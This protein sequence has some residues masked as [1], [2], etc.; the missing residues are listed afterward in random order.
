MLSDDTV[1][2]RL[3]AKLDHVELRFL[4]GI[5]FGIETADLSFRR[6]YELLV[7]V[8]ERAAS[9]SEIPAAIYPAAIA[10][11]WAAIDSMHRLKELLERTPQLKKN[12][13]EVALF[14]RAAEELNEL[15]N[16][17]H[18]AR[19]DFHRL[20]PRE[21]AIWGVV[22]WCVP[23]GEHITVLGLVPGTITEG[24]Y[25][26]LNPLGKV[27]QPPVDLIA[28]KAFGQT[29]QLSRLHRNLR[30]L[31][32]HLESEVVNRIVGM[33]GSRCDMLVCFDVAPTV[34]ADGS[35]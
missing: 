33:N 26:A 29:A 27:V 31:A 28:I 13:P 1:F 21:T 23:A 18:H 4:D 2:R 10:D 12:T 15:R 19:E 22:S 11:A 17:F 20:S 7:E 34:T 16:S 5:R 35:S 32:A 25:P 14:A 24:N 8:T 3:P 9:R 30:Q 6:L